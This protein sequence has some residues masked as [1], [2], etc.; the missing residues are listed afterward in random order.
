MSEK[1]VR[2][3]RGSA[4]FVGHPEGHPYRSEEQRYGSY[5]LAFVLLATGG[6]VCSLVTS[7]SV[8]THSD[9]F[10]EVSMEDDDDVRVVM[11][12]NPFETKILKLATNCK[13][14]PISEKYA[15]EVINSTFKAHK[16]KVHQEQ[17]WKRI[18]SEING[19][20]N[21][22]DDSDAAQDQMSHADD[23]EELE[24]VSEEAS[25]ND[26][27]DLEKQLEH[28]LASLL[29]KMQTVMHIPESAVQEVIQQ[30]CEINKPSQ[31]LLHNRV[32]AVLKKYY[33]DIN[34]TVVREVTGVVSESNIIAF[35]AKDG[36]LGTAK[37]RAAYVHRE[38]P[39][40]NPIEYCVEKGK[41]TLEYVPIVP[42]L[43][44]LL[45]KTDIL[46]KAM[47]EKVHVPQEYRSYVDGQCF[48]ENS[49]LARDKFTIALGLYIEDF[50]VANPLGT[51]KLKH[52]MCAIYWVIAN[53]PAKYRSTLNSIQLALL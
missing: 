3:K 32:R 12:R 50:E 15:S 53:I 27:R 1:N 19:L 26:L 25:E 11:G 4:G 22:S 45:N 34:E 29:L 28:N 5:V 17:N 18:K 40:V 8:L 10:D 36:S 49:L 37:R 48:N 13:A 38:F 44:K 24:D 35:C 41:K 46:D 31:P 42:M 16:S 2:T 47:S 33:V 14:I 51:S 43:Q 52:K 21:V 23:M 39:L 7:Y 20:D 6:H 30:L 9:G